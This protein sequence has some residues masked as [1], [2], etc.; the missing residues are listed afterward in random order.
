MEPAFGFG[1][2]RKFSK[3]NEI[4]NY[5]PTDFPTDTTDF[6]RSDTKLDPRVFSSELKLNAFLL[7]L[8]R[9]LQQML[10]ITMT[11]S[12]LMCS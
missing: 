9:V 4:F 7:D 11:C 12:L 3:N 10:L 5:I 6:P 1:S 8:A 2:T